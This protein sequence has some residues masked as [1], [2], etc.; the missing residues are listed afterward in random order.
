MT[1]EYYY[2]KKHFF[3]QGMLFFMVKKRPDF[4]NKY[5]RTCHPHKT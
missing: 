1:L 5:L 2:E 4:R 3:S